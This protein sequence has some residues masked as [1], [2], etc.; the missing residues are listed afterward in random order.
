M[1]NNIIVCLLA[2]IMAFCLIGH[3]MSQ[4][5]SDKQEKA[6]HFVLKIGEEFL[7][8]NDNKLPI[9]LQNDLF[10]KLRYIADTLILYKVEIRFAEENKNDFFVLSYKGGPAPQEVIAVLESTDFSVPIKL[11]THFDSAL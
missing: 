1:R 5:S 2:L 10:E 7:R 8:A 11:I 6:Y 3:A 9:H 4:D